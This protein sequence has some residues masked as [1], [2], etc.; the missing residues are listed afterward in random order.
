M[1]NIFTFLFAD[2]DHTYKTLIT[3][4]SIILAVVVM[5]EK[6]KFACL[7]K[8]AE[9]VAEVE[10]MENL[11]GK[12]K[13]AL[14]VLWINQSLPLIFRNKLFQT[15]LKKLIQ[16]A[17]EKSSDYAKNYIKRKTGYDISGVLENLPSQTEESSKDTN[18]DVATD[19]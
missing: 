11:T 5:F 12:Q 6:I 2:G 19:V 7:E 18:K 15:I 17:Y 14:V 3:L 13:F 10:G 8:A 9:K 1:D 4:L 16:Y